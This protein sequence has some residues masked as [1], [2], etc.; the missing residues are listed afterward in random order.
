[1]IR[2]QDEDGAPIAEFCQCYHDTVLRQKLKNA[3]LSMEYMKKSLEFDDG[4]TKA[5]VLRL[6]RDVAPLTVK[7][8]GQSQER[9]L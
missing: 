2:K 3:N 9:Q 8:K 4:L 1:M 6:K 7:K 5:T